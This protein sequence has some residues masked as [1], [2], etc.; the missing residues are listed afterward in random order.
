MVKDLTFSISITLSHRYCTNTWPFGAAYSTRLYVMMVLTVM[1]NFSLSKIKCFDNILI[2]T[3]SFFV[4]FATFVRIRI[5]FENNNYASSTSKPISKPGYCILIFSTGKDFRPNPLITNTFYSSCMCS[6]SDTSA[7]IIYQLCAIIVNISP[8]SW[9]FSCSEKAFFYL[10]AI[11]WRCL[12]NNMWVT[13][14]AN[15]FRFVRC[16]NFASLNI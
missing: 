7:T 4:C 11:S 9:A 6:S 15:Q 8:S 16:C 5:R 14:S 13:E 2:Q 1:T 3:N 12:R 10:F